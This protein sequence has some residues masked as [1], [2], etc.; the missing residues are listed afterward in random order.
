MTA[1]KWRGEA[2]F[3]IAGA[4]ILLRPTFSAL[5]AA[6]D[7]IGP[8]FDLV[9]R[10]AEGRLTLAEIATLFDHLSAGHRPPEID[11]SRIGE[12]IVARGL[13]GVTPQLKIVLKQIL[14]GR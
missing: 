2:S 12:A 10:A 11:R 3:D 1:N 5:V 7:E 13:A 6:E 8:L 4:P 14:A 9:E